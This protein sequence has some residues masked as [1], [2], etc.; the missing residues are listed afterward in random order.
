MPKDVLPSSAL[1]GTGDDD[2]EKYDNEKD[3]IDPNEN[4]RFL[5]E[6]LVNTQKMVICV[7]FTFSEIFIS[8]FILHILNVNVLK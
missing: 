2:E 5:S 6:C 8:N 3:Y 7:D 1:N 4:Q